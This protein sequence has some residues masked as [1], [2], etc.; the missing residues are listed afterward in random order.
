[1]GEIARLTGRID[2]A[3]S[4]HDRM[5]DLAVASAGGTTE[6]LNV[7]QAEYLIALDL[8]AA[9]NPR[10]AEA[11]QHLDTACQILSRVSPGLERTFECLLVSALL[12]QREGDRARAEREAVEGYQALRERFAADSPIVLDAAEVVARVRSQ[13]VGGRIP[14]WGPASERPRRQGLRE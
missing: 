11:R 5:R 14:P 6:H 2:E 10:L 8:A 3:L 13:E 7:G 9:P 1:L 4:L 12:A